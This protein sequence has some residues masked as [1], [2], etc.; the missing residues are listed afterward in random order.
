MYRFNELIKKIAEHAYL[1]SRFYSFIDVLDVIGID[2]DELD[3][4]L[5]QFREDNLGKYITSEKGFFGPIS[6]QITMDNIIEITDNIEFRIE[7]NMD[8]FRYLSCSW[9]QIW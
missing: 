4:E 3:K 1:Q 8:L 9:Y 2:I 7:K 6:S 5:E